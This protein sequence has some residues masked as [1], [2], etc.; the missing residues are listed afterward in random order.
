MAFDSGS[1]TIVPGDT[2]GYT[3]VFV[4]DM[5]TGTT[6]RVSVG[7][8]GEQITG[9]ASWTPSIS[10]DGRYVAFA[11]DAPNVV[12]G[13][14]GGNVYVRDRLLGT[15]EKVSVGLGGVAA[16]GGSYHPSISDDGRFVAFDSN[17]RNLVSPYT[18][19]SITSVF[20]YDRVTKMTQ[21]VS[22]RI[23]AGEQVNAA[24][25]SISSDGRFVAFDGQPQ[26]VPGQNPVASRDVYIRDRKAGTTVRASIPWGD[27][28]PTTSQRPS[29]S[30][31]GR[32]VVFDALW[33]IAPNPGG[34][35]VLAYNRVAKTITVVSL[36]PAGQIGNGFVWTGAT[37]SDNARYVA[38]SSDASD[39][40]AERYERGHRHVRPRP[41]EQED[42][43]RVDELVAATVDVLQQRA[44]DLGRRQLRRVP[45]ARQHAGGE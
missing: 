32:I 24:N 30:G 33:G 9:G 23:G 17:A 45:V 25:P 4:R 16:N 29:I 37:V 31:D 1:S 28:V 6:E 42:I 11:S 19:A 15:T 21:W 40:V 39:L 43:P 5:A 2:N 3:D 10:A 44:R 20:V 14:L 7:P 36:N 22:K 13:D 35:D 41:H 18:G 27:I 8:N 34:R 26:L 12:P 38:F